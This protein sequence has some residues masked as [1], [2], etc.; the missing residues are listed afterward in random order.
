MKYKQ[1]TS[2]KY[3]LFLNEISDV[4]KQRDKRTKR[5]NMLMMYCPNYFIGFTL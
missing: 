1:T 4:R 5:R 2:L 3:M